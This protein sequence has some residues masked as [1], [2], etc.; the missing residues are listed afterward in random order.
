MMTRRSP[1]IDPET[2]GRII[3]L[4]SMDAEYQ[5]DMQQQRDYYEGKQFIHLTDRLRQFLGGEAGVSNSDWKRIRLNIFRTII[6]AVVERLIVS[7]ITSDEKGRL[8]PL[9]DETGETILDS[10]GAPAA[11][12][13]KPTDTWTE[14][15]WS[16]N[17]MDARQ[18]QIYE[19][20]L[21]DSESFVLVA[22]DD[23]EKI[24]RFSL[25]PRYIDPRIE[26]GD[27][28]G[29]I[30]VYQNNDPEQELLFVVKRWTETSYPRGV[31]FDQQRMTLYFPD[32][33][34]KYAGMP[35]TWSPI[36]DPGDGA[37]PLPW[38]D[39]ESGEPLG[40]PVVH[41]R[42]TA[43]FEA[44]E[45]IGPQNAINKTLIDLLAAADLTAFQIL[46]ALG[47]EPIDSSGNPLP[48]SPGTW[49]GTPSSD[50]K[51]Q[52]VP[53]ADVG[54]L[55][56]QV[57]NWIQWAA[58]A[59]D[60][61]VSRFT[62]SRQVAAEGTMK[63]Q[64]T[65]LLNKTRMRQSELSIGIADMFVIA[66]KLHNTFWSAPRLD[67][68]VTLTVAWEPLEQRDEDAELNRAV[69]KA[70]K[71]SI[72][73]PQVWSELGYTEQQI[74][75]WTAE[76]EAKALEVARQ[77]RALPDQEAGQ[78]EPNQGGQQGDGSQQEQQQTAQS[79]QPG[80]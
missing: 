25:H 2:L 14:R 52:I 71:L 75:R 48:I 74:A 45:A 78:G 36:R 41:F 29:C 11:G 28:Y 40:I 15:T 4:G 58:M 16:N 65:P 18:R 7:R 57:F 80:G 23:Q 21:R 12:M 72:P 76:K 27:G 43:G 6:G 77:M 70:T 5:Q 22:W 39:P 30:A 26:G 68:D 31:R 63:E 35:N 1:S 38:T 34:E 54:G 13:I 59:T 60:T 19:A 9:R 55:S 61:P 46:I 49:L 79:G 24:A 42:S 62:M 53:P 10:S 3:A 67:P 44:G 37:W 69:I 66:R 50:G 51:V 73:L 20:T 8:A 33:I 32:R 17:R 47:W 64:N 56:D